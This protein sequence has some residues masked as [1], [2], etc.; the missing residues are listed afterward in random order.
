LP[1]AYISKV[2]VYGRSVDLDQVLG[3]IQDLVGKEQDVRPEDI[4]VA[5]RYPGTSGSRQGIRRR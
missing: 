4:R 2:I 3:Y 5:S 1:G